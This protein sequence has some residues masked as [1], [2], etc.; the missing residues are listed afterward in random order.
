M[1]FPMDMKK[2]FS[3]FQPVVT[4][5]SWQVQPSSGNLKHNRGMKQLH[6]NYLGS[7]KMA[8]E[9][10][11][12]VNL[13]GINLCSTESGKYPCCPVTKK[14]LSWTESSVNLR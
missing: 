10:D 4:G 2:Y 5:L 13:E 14:I 7:I 3:L 8:Q 9:N 11:T 12:A 6:K 1:V